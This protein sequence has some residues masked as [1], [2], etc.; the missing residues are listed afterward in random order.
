M[1]TL[2]VIIL[3]AVIGYIGW[4]MYQ[5]I[6]PDLEPVYGPTVSPPIGPPPAPPID[7]NGKG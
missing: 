5:E 4:F 6:Q 3:V 2:I 1:K 7:E